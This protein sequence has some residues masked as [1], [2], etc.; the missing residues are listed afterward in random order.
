[1]SHSGEPVPKGS[2]GEIWVRGPNVFLGYLKNP[3]ASQAAVTKDGWYRTG[4]AG[5]QDD[6]GNL[7]ITDRIKELVKYKGF[8]VA[9]AELEGILVSHSKVADACVVGLYDESEA[10]EVPR[11]FVVLTVKVE[12]AAAVES[13]IQ[14]WVQERV[15]SYKRLRGGVELVDQIPK[16]A[17]GKVLRRVLKDRALEKEKRQQAGNESSLRAKI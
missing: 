8:Q 16:T 3:A 1:M 14:R 2:S 5:Y 4:D 6:K 13:E 11:A 12:N 7:Y 10:T 15:V 17:S 9:P